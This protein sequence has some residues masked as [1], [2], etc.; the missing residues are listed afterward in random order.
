MLTDAPPLSGAYPFVPLKSMEQIKYI[1]YSILILLGAA[2]TYAVMKPM[3][4]TQWVKVETD[5]PAY[6]G[7]ADYEEPVIKNMIGKN[8]FNA[9]CATCHSFHKILTGPTLAGVEERG[10][11]T[12]RENLVKWVHNPAAFLATNPYVKELA[13]QFNGQIMPS[14]P[15]MS[16]A[17]INQIFDYIKE[18]SAQPPQSV[19]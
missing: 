17:D 6:C 8:I 2:A 9:N 12:K 13:V 11:W 14:F 7:T 4:K 10:P 19:Q 5:E 15:Q 16:E 18:A 3:V 1:L